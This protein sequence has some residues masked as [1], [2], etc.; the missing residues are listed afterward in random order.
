MSESVTQAPISVTIGA[1]AS[2]AVAIRSHRLI[3]DQTVRGGG[4]DR[5]PEPIELL[6]AALGSCVALYI[7]R[8]CEARGLATTGLRVEVEQRGV[9]GP[10]RIGE[11][12]VRVI[13][14]L[15]IPN[16]YTE[17]LERV[18]RSCP[19]HNTLTNGATIRVSLDRLIAASE[20]AIEH[21]SA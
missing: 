7:R 17:M 12:V 8:F 18:A 5:G 15:S 21:A 19:V 2:S 6:G 20:P 1:G 4:E 3:V 10:H 14:P 16:R 13:L 11:F 9:T